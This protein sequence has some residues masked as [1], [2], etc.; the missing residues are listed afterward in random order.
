MVRE[1]QWTGQLGE[2]P[3]APTLPLAF[4]REPRGA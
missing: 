2:T 3:K 4:N 1:P